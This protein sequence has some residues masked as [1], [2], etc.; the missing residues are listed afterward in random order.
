MAHDSISSF[1][2]QNVLSIL[3]CIFVFVLAALLVAE[4]VKRFQNGRSSVWILISSLLGILI[5]GLV[6]KFLNFDQWRFGHSIFAGAIMP[7]IMRTGNRLNRGRD[8]KFATAAELAQMFY[9][10]GVITVFSLIFWLDIWGFPILMAVVFL[11]L[12]GINMLFYAIVVHEQNYQY[13]SD[14]MLKIRNAAKI[15]ATQEIEDI[16]DYVLLKQ[17]DHQLNKLLVD[18]GDRCDMRNCFR[19][20]LGSCKYYEAKKAA[21]EGLRGCEIP[22][23]QR[24][25]VRKKL[26]QMSEVE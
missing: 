16:S 19:K 9:T 26:A 22:L 8:F 12:F 14:Q 13:N 10:S 4:L 25:L 17:K 3:L 5:C 21:P 23:L 2:A 11:L 15:I 7:L 24:E 1:V 18:S 20:G 6:V